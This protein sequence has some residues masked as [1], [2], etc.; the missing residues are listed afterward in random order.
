MGMGSGDGG[1][2]ADD[3]R[4]TGNNGLTVRKIP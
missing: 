2:V 3:G 1:I 4:G